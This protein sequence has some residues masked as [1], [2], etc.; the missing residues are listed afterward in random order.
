MIL[1]WRTD[2]NKKRTL[3]KESR[4][5]FFTIYFSGPK[6]RSIP[7]CVTSPVPADFLASASVNLGG[8]F[9]YPVQACLTVIGANPQRSAASFAVIMSSNIF[10]YLFRCFVNR[11]R[12]TIIKKYASNSSIFLVLLAFSCRLYAVFCSVIVLLLS[13]NLMTQMVP[14]ISKGNTNLSRIADHPVSD[15]AWA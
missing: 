12:L 8:A 13:T 10:S 6:S 14:L 1:Y 11:F 2:C 3:S 5:F 15:V 7:A 9:L 4:T